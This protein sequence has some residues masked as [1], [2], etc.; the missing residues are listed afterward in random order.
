[1]LFS[2]QE[3][4][5]PNQWDARTLRNKYLTHFLHSCLKG[6]VF[7]Y[8]V[9]TPILTYLKSIYGYLSCVSLG[10]LRPLKLT[11]KPQVALHF[12]LHTYP[13]Y[14]HTYIPIYQ[15]SKYLHMYVYVN[16]IRQCPIENVDVEYFAM[17]SLP[18]WHSVRFFITVIV[19]YFKFKY[20][21]FHF[22]L[23]YLFA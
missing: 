13:I 10:S 5:Y 19:S 11:Q 16:A 22:T 2:V 21:N 18:S 14:I 7:R 1:M 4:A 12:S 6:I 3:K 20:Y 9:T 17:A 15:E 8:T 23:M